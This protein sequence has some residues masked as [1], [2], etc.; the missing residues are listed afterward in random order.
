M[1]ADEMCALLL[2]EGFPALDDVNGLEDY[3][4]K[5]IAKFNGPLSRLEL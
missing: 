4:V 2:R 3:R 1:P 5:G